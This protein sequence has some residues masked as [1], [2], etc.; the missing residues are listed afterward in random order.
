M[1]VNQDEVLKAYKIKEKRLEYCK[2]YNINPRKIMTIS[3]E[4]ITKKRVN[5]TLDTNKMRSWNKNDLNIAIITL[6]YMYEEIYNL[7][8]EQV[9]ALWKD[10]KEDERKFLDATVTKSL[11]LKI[12]SESSKETLKDCLFNNKKII[13]KTLYPEYYNHTYNSK[14]NILTDV[15]NADAT[16]IRDLRAAGRFK[17]AIKGSKHNN[18]GALVDEII[19]EG[20]EANF[21]IREKIRNY[22]DKLLFLAQSKQN[23]FKDLGLMRLIE[24]RGCYASALDFYYLNSSEDLQKEYFYDYLDLRNQYQKRDDISFIINQ[25]ADNT[26]ELC[27]Y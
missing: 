5:N 15:I 6:K 12:I 9:D 3:R 1:S 18:N 14:Y 7:S 11:V 4:L 23:H 20:I 21:D 22:P 2:E 13:L 24:S 25:V 19:K 10:N 16:T 17:A 8:P 26:E 27:L